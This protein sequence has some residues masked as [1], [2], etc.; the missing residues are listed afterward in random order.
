MRAGALE[1][2]LRDAQD[3]GY[4]REI[5]DAETTMIHPGH[6]ADDAGLE[7][8][9]DRLDTFI[10]TLQGYAEPTLALAL[11][12]HLA[13]LLQAMVEHRVWTRQDARRFVLELEREALGV[14]DE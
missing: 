10:D 9:V 6:D 12:I 8:C 1:I 2:P 5:A 14:G 4:R 13:A 7:V 11:R 3:L